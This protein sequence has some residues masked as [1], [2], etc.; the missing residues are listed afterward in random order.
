M[1]GFS[2]IEIRKIFFQRPYL[3]TKEK[4]HSLY[5][6]VHLGIFLNPTDLFPNVTSR[7]GGGRSRVWK[8]HKTYYLSMA[9]QIPVQV[10]AIETCF[11]SIDELLV[12]WIVSKSRSPHIREELNMK[13]I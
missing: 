13:E 9:K 6:G 12:P 10:P 2:L 4:I 8:R 3:R 1:L 5:R 7:G 11:M